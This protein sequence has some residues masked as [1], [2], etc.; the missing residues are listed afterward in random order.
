MAVMPKPCSRSSCSNV[1]TPSATHSIRS[2]RAICAIPRTIAAVRD[3][4]QTFCEKR[5]SIFIFEMGKSFR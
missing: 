3:D 2:S 1:S 5:L 4:T